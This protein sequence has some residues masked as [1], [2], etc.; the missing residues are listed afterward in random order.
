MASSASKLGSLIAEAV[1]EAAQRVLSGNWANNDNDAGGC[2]GAQT[3]GRASP[4]QAAPARPR[5]RSRQQNPPP[6]PK[7][8]AAKPKR[9]TTRKRTADDQRRRLANRP[10]A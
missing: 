2:D 7:S 3:G 5:R 9:K 4:A 8:T 1:A 10:L 6:K